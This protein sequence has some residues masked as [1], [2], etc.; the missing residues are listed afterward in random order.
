MSSGIAKPPDAGSV[1]DSP[2]SS[3]A[4]SATAIRGGA[5]RVIG[6]AAGVLVSLGSATILV[7]YLGI[8]SFGRFVTVTSLVALVGGVTEAG[9]HVFGIREFV[10]HEEPERGVLLAQLLSM[11]LALTATGIACAILFGLI[12]GYSTVLVLGTAVAGV[13]LL[14]QVASDV[15]SISLQ[16]RLQ[17]GRLTVVDFSRRLLALLA[18]GGLALADASLLPFFA[19]S[20]LAGAI[21]LG[22]LAWLVR[23]S[24]KLR[25]TVDV[26]AWRRLFAETLPYAVA[27]SIGAIYFY[28]T[29]IV[30][31]LAASAKQTGLFG[32]SFRVTQVAL[33]VPVLLLTAIFP[34]IAREHAVADRDSG[35]TVGKVFKVAVI[36]GVWMSL[37]MLVGAPFIIDVI[38]GNAA[39][40]A[41]SV[42]QIQGSVLTLSFISASSGLTLIALKRYQP[43]I[44]TSSAALVLDVILALALIP[45]LGARGGA[46]ADVITEALVALA[47]TVTLTR[48]MP[49]HQ[50]NA[51][52]LPPLILATGLAV[53]VLLVPIGAVGRIIVVTFIYFG[54]LA[55]ARALPHEL[56]AAARL[57]SV[58]AH[59]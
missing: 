38:G 29:V 3:T 32:T 18:I 50:I 52:F 6:Y 31:S 25:L 45:S 17:L 39:R 14:F 30:M 26:A 58:R 15:F 2:P 48:P 46:I 53:L 20:T 12:V 4:D 9:I 37:V 24:L 55:L 51:A 5:V 27:M 13:G 56:T 11:R 28:V 23:A 7:R 33:G 35:E 57:R 44:L 43:M 22:L 19:T 59:R 36:C 16:A 10:A 1:S 49:E 8:S 40:G 47:L 54:V 42:L 34:L 21:A 41:R